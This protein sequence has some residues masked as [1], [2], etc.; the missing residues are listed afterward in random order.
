MPL[1]KRALDPR[2]PYYIYE[3]AYGPK[4][5]YVGISHSQLRMR[6]RWGH[7][8]NLIRHEGAQTLKPDKAKALATKSNQVI[9]RLIWAGMPPFEVQC[10]WEGVGKRAAEAQEESQIRLRL[11]QGCLLANQQHV[12]T[13]FD[14]DTIV[15][16]LAP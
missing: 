2:T 1:G 8:N 10:V 4:V 14:V 13:G 11:S 16:W 12:P 5:F 6:G 7:I 15:A 3:F 9:A